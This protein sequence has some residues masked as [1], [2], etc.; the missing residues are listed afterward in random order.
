MI[1]SFAKLNLKELS[2]CHKPKLSNPEIFATFVNLWYLT[3]I[4][5]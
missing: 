3:E 4:I 1:K 2:I 5:I